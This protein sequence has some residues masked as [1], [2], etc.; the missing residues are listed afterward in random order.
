MSCIG[1]WPINRFQRSWNIRSLTAS[2]IILISC[3]VSIL[4]GSH[5]I[6]SLSNP[7]VPFHGLKSQCYPHNFKFIAW[8]VSWQVSSNQI[9]IY[10]CICGFTDPFLLLPRLISQKGIVLEVFNLYYGAVLFYIY[11]TWKSERLTLVESGQLLKS[12]QYCFAFGEKKSLKFIEIVS[13]E[14]NLYA[15]KMSHST[16]SVSKTI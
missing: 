5:R 6:I 9:H 7:R 13:K 2:G 16:W 10:S 14:L 4:I 3:N 8:R 1:V 15:E 11:D 12:K